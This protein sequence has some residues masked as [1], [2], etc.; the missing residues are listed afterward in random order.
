MLLEKE[1]AGVPMQGC[2]FTIQT[3]SEGIG[4]NARKAMAA[5]TAQPWILVLSKTLAT[6]EQCARVAL[7]P[8]TDVCAP[9]DFLVKTA[10]H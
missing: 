1:M 5:H 7:R 9:P 10:I 2:A 8:T 6:M 4:A 3:T